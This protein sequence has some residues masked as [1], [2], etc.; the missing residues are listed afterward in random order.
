MI[1]LTALIYEWQNRIL[2]TEGII[3]EIQTEI[4]AGIISKPIKVITG[5]RRSGKS[6]LVNQLAQKLIKQKNYR[7]EDVLYINFEDNRLLELQNL[8]GISLIY[9]T[10]RKEISQNKKKLIIFDEIQLIPE[11][12]RFIRS[13]YERDNDINIIIT[14]SNSDLLSSELSSKLAGRS[15]EYRIFPFSFKEFLVYKNFIIK[16]K[17]DYFRYK[18]KIDT[19]YYK[20]FKYGGLPEIFSINSESA[21]YTYLEGIVN[22]II[23]DD[24][25][26]RFKIKNIALL[27]E[28]MNYVI[29]GIGNIIFASKLTNKIKNI[30]NISIKQSTITE[31]ISYFIKSYTLFEIHKFQ[32]K[33]SRVFE[34]TKKYYSIDL[35]IIN[36]RTTSYNNI[37]SYKLENLVFL[38]LL[39]KNKYIYFGQNELGKEIDF[40]V[41]N[42]K[43]FDKYQIAQTIT[44]DNINREYG[45]LILADKHLSKGK[46]FLI[47]NDNTEKITYKG[48]I[49]H[50]INII[51]F[52]LDFS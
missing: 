22:K 38:Q 18:E 3:R 15:I 2:R 43:V 7:L 10:F 51:E 41:P 49:I 9:S 34:K 42:N 44:P 45:N 29:S 31:Y 14:G 48:I 16:E 20:F 12:E 52:L 8:K 47:T 26:K 11:W 4:L 27:E 33:Q 37:D 17:K 28:V 40:I 30:K 24:I 46:N 13:I 19:L 35:G 32:W 39:R 5:F 25:V 23:L 36:T 50:K 6:F 1:N 21:K